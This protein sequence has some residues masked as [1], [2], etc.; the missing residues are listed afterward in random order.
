MAF[1]PRRHR[2][3][4]GR[5]GWPRPLRGLVRDAP[6][7][8]DLPGLRRPP[9]GLARQLEALPRADALRRRRAERLGRGGDGR[10]RRADGRL[11]VEPR[12]PQAAGAS[13]RSSPGPA[14]LISIRPGATTFKGSGSTSRP[15]RGPRS[16]GRPRSTWW[17]P[18]PAAGS[19]TASAKAAS[20][21]PD[22][23]GPRRPTDGRAA[24]SPSGTW[25][26]AVVPVRQGRQLPGRGAGGE[27]EH[28]RRPPP[29]GGGRRAGL[30]WP[31]PIPARRAACSRSTGS[32]ALRPYHEVIP[33]ATTYSAN[34][35]LQKPATSDRNWDVPINANTDALDA[36]TAV[37]GLASTP[38]EIPS[39][40]L[41]VRRRRRATSASRTARSA[42]SRACR[43]TPSRRRRRPTSG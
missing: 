6:C 23:A 10:G 8:V 33:L 19:T 35:R 43:A 30:G 16:A 15:P 9:A 17:R 31:R 1:L 11:L 13:G 24:R 5:G 14:A 12:R 7:R 21:A 26:F 36:M 27:R 25:Q 28:Q 18:T 37:G 41:Q 38:T 42:P 4:P 2:R 3:R 32:P 29:P 22:S 34:A 20:A 40:T 39:A